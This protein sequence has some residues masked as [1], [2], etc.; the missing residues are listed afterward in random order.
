METG[1]N[2]GGGVLTD[3]QIR[4]R[5]HVFGDDINTDIHCSSKYMPGKDI[6]YVARHAFE[7]LDSK[8]VGRFKKGDLIVAG[9][10]FGNNSSREQAVQI[11]RHIGIS[12]IVARSFSRQLFRNAINNGLPVIECDTGD[13]ET[14]DIIEV[15]LASGNV[16]AP[17]KN[18]HRHSSQLPRELLAFLKSGGLIPFLK[19]NPS[20]QM[21]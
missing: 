16:S 13:M 8:F 10:N 6:D 20:W 9:K 5:A 2:E 17:D 12:A 21:E 7:N 19:A 14:G 3:I 4:G 15:D 1:M 11:M 18:I